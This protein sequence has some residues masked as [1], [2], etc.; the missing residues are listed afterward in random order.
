MAD[1]I[2]DFLSLQYSDNFALEGIEEKNIDLTLPPA[3]ELSAVVYGTVTDGELPVPNATVKLFDSAGQPF[4]HTMTD[5]TGAY[6]ISD[7]LAGTYSVGA[8]ADGYRLSEPKYVTLIGGDTTEI[9]LLCQKDVSL[10]LG[11][12]AG[13]LSA[14]LLP[15]GT[16]PLAGAKI[17]LQDSL[18]AAV[19]VTYSADDGEF[20]FYDVADGVYTV[21]ASADGYISVTSA[22]TISG[23]S[24]AN[25]TLLMGIDTRTYNGTVSGIVKNSSGYTVADCFV[26][27]YK[28]EDDGMG[29]TREILVS[30][31]KTNAEG[32]YMFGNVDG[33]S[34]LVKAKLNA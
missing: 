11:A 17:T 19:A 9:N 3:P 15:A 30:T 32:K 31:T 2:K 13:V 8:V 4:K 7:I 16:T 24:I 5:I 22:V 23:G 28:T 6:T 27:L 10:T 25:I 33:G 12:I 20:V 34:Y 29:G 1:I 14:S 26:G 21:F 18:G